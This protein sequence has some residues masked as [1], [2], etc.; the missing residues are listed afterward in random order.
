MKVMPMSNQKMI[1]DLL[2]H[3][4]KLRQNR[5][6]TKTKKLSLPRRV[7]MINHDNMYNDDLKVFE[8]FWCA[9]MIHGG[10]LGAVTRNVN[11]GFL[12]AYHLPYASAMS[13][14]MSRAKLRI[15]LP[16]K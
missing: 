14:I 13:E 3:C 6:K 12:V 5:L 11:F 16:N 2:S 1:L 8:T 4:D 7:P 15:H 9:N 10:L